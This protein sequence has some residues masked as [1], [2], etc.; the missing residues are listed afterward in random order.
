[1]RSPRPVTTAARRPAA[2]ISRSSAASS[3]MVRL[4]VSDSRRCLELA[5]GQDA[6]RDRG[7]RTAGRLERAADG[8]EVARDLGPAL[9]D[10]VPAEGDEVPADASRDTHVAADGDEGPSERP[11][12][13]RLPAEDD[14]VSLV[15][16]ARGD[17]GPLLGPGEGGREEEENGE[18]GPAGHLRARLSPARGRR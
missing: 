6:P 2:S 15:R 5:D 18:E 11:A 3:W 1:M 10:D 17:G 8:E 13:D 7:P 12:H 9:E 4:T 16:S 14:E